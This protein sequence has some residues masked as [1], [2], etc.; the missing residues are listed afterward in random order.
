MTR[1]AQVAQ[2][3]CTYFFFSMYHLVIS[4]LNCNLNNLSKT[5][6]RTKIYSSSLSKELVLDF[7]LVKIILKYQSS[8][9]STKML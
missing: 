2:W 5:K 3:R 8:L 7:I 1:L 9:H 6:L 4:N